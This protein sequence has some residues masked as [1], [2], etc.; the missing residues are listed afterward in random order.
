M[1]TQSNPNLGNA[2]VRSISTYESW[3]RRGTRRLM[4]DEVYMGWRGCLFDTLHK[5]EIVCVRTLAL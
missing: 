1:R 5:H 4:P 2:I 3:P